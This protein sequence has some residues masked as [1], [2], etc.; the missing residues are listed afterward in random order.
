MKKTLDTALK[1]L[2]ERSKDAEIAFFGGSFTAIKREY[3]ISLLDAAK[4]YTDRFKGIRISTRPDCIDDEVLSLLKTYHVTSIE[5]GA[6]SMDDDVLTLN[7]RG[8]DSIDVKNASDKIKKYGFSLGLQMMTGLY[9]SNDEKDIYT[10][11]EFIRLHPDTVRIYPTIVMKNTRLGQLYL[12]NEYVPQTLESAVSLCS[13]LLKIF[14]EH[15]IKVIRLGLH[16]SE[17]LKR[18]ML[19]GPYHPSFRELCE[20]KRMYDDFMSLFHKGGFDKERCINVYLNERS[21]S[22]FSGNRKSNI[23]KINSQGIDVKIMKDNTLGIFDMRL[24]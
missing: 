2:N 9:G 13:D 22:K 6:Q 4:E 21:I 7:D 23:L 14:E 18:D 16:D 24:S 8:H 15:K 19:S 20:S 17:S 10:A 12:S 11:N 1:S 3:M 5:L